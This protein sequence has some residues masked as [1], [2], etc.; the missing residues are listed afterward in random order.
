MIMPV[1]ATDHI[2]E[3]LILVIRFTRARRRVLVNNLRRMDKEGFVPRDLAVQEFAEQLHSAINEHVLHRRLVLRDGPHLRFGAR[4]RMEP[5]PETD[6]E[7]RE[8]LQSDPE[9][10]LRYQTQRLAETS[11]NER[12]ALKMLRRHV[13]HTLAHQL[14][15]GAG[16]SRPIPPSDRMTLTDGRMDL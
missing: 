6:A 4:G 8:L 10:Y 2:Q 14:D 15:R 3:L 13:E 9:A 5:L 11:L 12:M 7:A 1:Q 16:S